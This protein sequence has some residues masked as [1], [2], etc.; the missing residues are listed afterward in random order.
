MGV[1]D[2]VILVKININFREY[3]SGKPEKL[4]TLGTQ[5]QETQN[6]KNSTIFVGHHYVQTNTNNVNK[7]CALL[8]TNTNNVNKT[9]ALLQT[10]T[11]NVNKTCALLQTNTNNVNKTC[12]LLQT[13]THNVNK[14][15][16]LLQTS[17]RKENPNNIVLCG[18]RNGHHNTE[19]RM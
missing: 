17:G 10:N 19:F 18:H 6:K 2:G 7:T 4:A 15:C 14:T 8:Q 5:D 9:C 12:A 16:A 3:R 1:R 11:N 13:N